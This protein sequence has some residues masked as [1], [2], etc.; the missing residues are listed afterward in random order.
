MTTFMKKGE[1]FT[2]VRTVKPEKKRWLELSD[3]QV[4]CIEEAL[5]T[6]DKSIPGVIALQE[7]IRGV[8]EIKVR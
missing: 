3:W 4:A 1:T 7:L 5:R 6:C 2:G 8:R